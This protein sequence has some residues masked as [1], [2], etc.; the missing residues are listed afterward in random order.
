MKKN[1]P[2]KE[3]LKKLLAEIEKEDAEKRLQEIL[4]DPNNKFVKM[5][6]E[7]VEKRKEKRNF[8]KSSSSYF[9]HNFLKNTKIKSEFKKQLLE[10]LIK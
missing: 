3:S 9:V 7:E 10:K 6:L 5:L 4:L 8:L 2:K 1:K